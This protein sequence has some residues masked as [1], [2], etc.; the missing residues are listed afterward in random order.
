MSISYPTSAACAG[1]AQ[2]TIQFSVNYGFHIPLL[3]FILISQRH[4]MTANHKLVYAS[5]SCTIVMKS[6]SLTAATLQYKSQRPTSAWP[7]NIF[8]CEASLSSRFIMQSS[9]I[10]VIQRNAN[11]VNTT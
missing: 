1:T 5:V 4:I 7:S 11:T 9:A 2:Q 3:T 6:V 10:V 8:S